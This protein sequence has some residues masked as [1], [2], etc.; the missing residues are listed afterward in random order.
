MRNPF[1]FCLVLGICALSLGMGRHGQY[2]DEAREFERMEKEYKKAGYAAETNTDSVGDIA[3]GVKQATYDSTKGLLQDT[4]EGTASNAPVVGT[5]QGAVK[6][7]GKVL[8]NTSKGIAEIVT[9]GRADRDSFRVE[10]PEHRSDD[11]TKVKFNF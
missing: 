5:V 9:L 10:E 7:S 2:D 4:A 1:K 8:E 6:G 3:G 11:T